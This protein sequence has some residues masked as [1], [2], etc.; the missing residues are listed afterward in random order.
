MLLQ[1]IKRDKQSKLDPLLLKLLKKSKK[2]KQSKI[3]LHN[4]LKAS[5]RFQWHAYK[6]SPLILWSI[7]IM[8]ASIKPS[9]YYILDHYLIIN[10]NLSDQRI[11]FC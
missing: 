9:D 8:H 3:G 7:S 11:D 10:I 1:D 4:S 2:D 5:K 6:K